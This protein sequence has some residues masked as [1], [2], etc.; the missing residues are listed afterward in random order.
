MTCPE[1]TKQAKERESWITTM[2]VTPTG[3]VYNTTPIGSDVC[4][5]CYEREERIALGDL[6]RILEF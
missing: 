2:T 6:A 1:C 4:E 5:E 3:P